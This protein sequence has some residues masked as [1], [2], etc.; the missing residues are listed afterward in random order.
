MSAILLRCW[1][2]LMTFALLPFAASAQIPM[3]AQKQQQSIL[4]L[5]ATAH[6]G[7]GEVIK[8]AAIGFRE[9]KID[10]VL[11]AIDIRMDSTKYDTIIYAEGQQLYPGFIA[12][13]SR[14]GLVEIDAVRASR[15]YDDVGL[16]NPHVRALT[17]YNT[18]SRITPTVRTN[19]VLM[20]QV[21]PKGGRISGTSSIFSLEGWN[22][23]DAVI[24]QDDGIHMNWPN[25]RKQLVKGQA[26][27]K[28]KNST[29]DN[30]KK[31]TQEII[32][33]FLQAQ[34]Y[35]KDEFPLE[36]NLRFE[37]MKP[38]FTR[39]AKLFVHAQRVQEL[40][41]AIYFADQFNLEIVVVGAY[42]APLVADLLKDRNI[43]V[44]L[45]RVHSLPRYEDDNID[46]PFRLAFILHK[47]GLL[48]GLENSG[49]MEAM[50]SRNLPF[51]AGTVAAYGLDQETALS[52]ICLN[53]AKILGI[54]HLVGSIEEGKLA[55]FFISE[56]DALDMRT[57][58]VVL[59]FVEGKQIK[60]DNPQKLLY[61][62]YSNKYKQ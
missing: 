30:Y 29:K 32:D 49:S 19:G 8:R 34:A 9:G 3:P 50:G 37:A 21:A 14:L 53:T 4:I 43:P 59:A 26:S 28:G 24:R 57:N 20:A 54:D 62:K 44:L 38:L 48:V 52:M 27:D 36:K 39:K 22:W 55:T 42:E 16:F 11:A 41:D 1:I 45:R 18:E 56:G 23:E 12:P 17:A 40:T 5:N 33:F 47:K 46:L 60:L 15:D 31:N 35:T 10:M 7:N 25:Y 58:K 6:L 13:N 51:Y 61:R 2:S